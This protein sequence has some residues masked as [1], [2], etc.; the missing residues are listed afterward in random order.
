LDIY[1]PNLNG[2][3]VLKEMKKRF[4]KRPFS[5]CVTADQNTPIT[6]SALTQGALD[7]IHKDQIHVKHG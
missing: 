3:E 5:W 6:I 4:L 7:F 1:L 2:L